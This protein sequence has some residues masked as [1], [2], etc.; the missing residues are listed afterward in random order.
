MKD[1]QKADQVTLRN[2]IT[3]LQ[4]GRFVVPDFQR[5]FEW[6][7]SDI[8]E[9]VRSVFLDYY[10]GSLLLW[11]G[12]KNNFDAL[13]C[14]AIYGYEGSDRDRKHIVLDGQQ[15]L[16]ALY[17]AFV[18]PRIR[19]PRKKNRFLYFVRVDKFMD[20]MYDEAFY[21]DWTRRGTNLLEDR[22]TQFEQHE[23]PLSVIGDMWNLFPWVEDYCRH[24]E[25]KA[26]SAEANEAADMQLARLHAKNARA[27]KKHIVDITQEYQITYVEL[28]RDLEI[29]KICDIFTQT[30]SRGVRLDVFDLINALVRPKGIKLKSLWRKEAH[31]FSFLDDH[32]MNVYV[33]QIMSILMQN[34]CSPKY[35]YYLIPGQKKKV[36]RPDGCRHE[37]LVHSNS[38][39]VALWHRAVDALER[40]VKLL[41]HSREY[42]ATA[43]H[44]LP[45]I[46]ILPAFAALLATSDDLPQTS[47]L[48]A[49]N[50]IRQW[51]WA[52]VFE[53]RYSGSVLT[54]TARD[55]L[56]VK[57]WYTDDAAEPQTVSEFK[58][59]F[60]ELDLRQYS[61]P[62]TA[63]YKG[64]LCLMI[65]KGARD[66]S[67]GKAVDAA[68]CHVDH[69]IPQ[70]WGA[71]NRCVKQV[72]SI[73]NRVPVTA[74]TS[75][76]II[77]NRLPN[78]Y[79]PEL[80]GVEDERSVRKILGT[81]FISPLA[82]DI[83]LREPFGK[84]DFDE[85]LDERQRTYLEGVET[86]LLTRHAELPDRLMKP[87][88]RLE[89]VEQ[90]LRD[91]IR[92]ALE[93]DPA[94]LPPDV[95]KKIR[96]RLS[97][98]LRRNPDLDR[99]QFRRLAGQMEYSSLG[100]LHD[101][102][103]NKKL[104][105]LFEKV[106]SS[107]DHLRM[108]FGQLLE[109]RNALAHGRTVSEIVRIDGEAAILWFE[110]LLRE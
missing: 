40:A 30:N 98:A 110:K 39:F 52:S 34:Y 57:K 41:R 1:V 26:A 38:D 51:Y 44:F 62:S 82:I 74:Q 33:L 54:T 101:V 36:R 70:S 56:D 8:R 66:W 104:W 3:W 105:H 84:D 106:F 27:F 29:D 46:S 80:F 58:N 108:R 32:R 67:T 102:I 55:F 76:G 23:F 88:A 85:F 107:K 93:D 92:D 68:H 65:L 75:R 83:L 103:R 81:H 99:D 48:D 95:G 77:K 50:T 13:A 17:Y 43:A 63:V 97:P 90:L 72:E 91:L 60:R 78:V 61:K 2:L 4:E 7:P 14:E 12:N 28:D 11:R 18:A 69:V 31:R 45:Y 6:Q 64:I 100:E 21:Y 24:W 9:L 86:L 96:Q 87:K 37:V 5:E 73:L 71:K 49:N 79:L 16:T 59:R 94:K 10:I 47:I 35:L 25:Q 109:L 19:A 89:N 53:R 15:R 20:E 22:T 42:G